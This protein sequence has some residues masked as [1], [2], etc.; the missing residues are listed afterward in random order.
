MSSRQYSRVSTPGCGEDGPYSLA[1][2]GWFRLLRGRVIGVRTTSRIVETALVSGER[3]QR[4]F[5]MVFVG[6]GFDADEVEEYAAEVRRLCL[7]ITSTQPF[8]R[9]RSLLNLYRVDG[10]VDRA[11]DRL[12]ALGVN[13]SLED[14]RLMTVD[15]D[16]AIAKARA[17][18]H[19]ADLVLVV[20]NTTRYGGSA[21]RV[22]VTTRHPRGG[23]LLL[24]E[25][26]HA[27]FDLADEYGPGGER[28]PGP[29][30][31]RVNV[32][33]ERDPARSKWA[34]LLA[35]DGSV[36]CFEGGDRYEYGVYR[37]Q[38]NCRMR[39]LQAPFCV[40]CSRAITRTLLA[41][42]HA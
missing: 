21:G 2:P 28:H 7:E 4:R 38:S 3:S 31:R 18:V 36:G 33:L 29:E 27:G 12:G 25:I 16:Q 13:V 6:A 30:P 11:V 40:V 14:Q 32:T 9:L 42:A 35:L 34:D 1:R 26:G 10:A 20:V 37:P 19:T 17:S 39:S 41:H 24:H 5:D 22:A 23:A 15:D 8:S